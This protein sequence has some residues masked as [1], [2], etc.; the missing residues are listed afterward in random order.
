MWAETKI[1]QGPGCHSKAAFAL[2]SYVFFES[3]YNAT[4]PTK[5]PLILPVRNDLPSMELLQRFFFFILSGFF[6]S[7]IYYIFYCHSWWS[8]E[9][10]ELEFRRQ[11]IYSQGITLS[12]SCSL[13]AFGRSVTL[14]CL[15]YKFW[16]I[17]L[18]NI[19]HTELLYVKVLW[20][21]GSVT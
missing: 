6:F 17:I 2:E 8:E 14:I 21:L 20:K 1:I 7:G 3:G 18:T 4:F 15:I 13:S 16:V 10:R 19:C 5:P 9:N 11:G 12:H